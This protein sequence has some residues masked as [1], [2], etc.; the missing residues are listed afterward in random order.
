MP[1]ISA[2][3]AASLVQEPAADA[4]KLLDAVVDKM[5]DSEI[6]AFEAEQ[7]LGTNGQGKTKCYLKRPD[8][9]R[10]DWGG[11]LVLFDG[12]TQW[13]YFAGSKT[14]SRNSVKGVPPYKGYGP[15]YDLFFHKTSEPFL[16]GDR[17][18]VSVK[19]EKVGKAEFEVVTWKGKDGDTRLWI[20]KDK[21]IY[22]YDETW[23]ADGKPL[24]VTVSFAGWSLQPKL[25]EDFFTFTP[26]KG[27]KEE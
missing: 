2:W 23:L 27:A 16:R 18:A 22:R 13:T 3:L 8:K 15:I 17:G 5:K 12:S 6:I 11:Q 26:P 1:L 24:L 21:L 7:T 20:D 4:K 25:A 14:Y 19:R 9:A 10:F